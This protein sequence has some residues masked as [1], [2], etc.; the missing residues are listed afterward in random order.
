M[1][2]S[3]E[4]EKKVETVPAGEEVSLKIEET[5]PETSKEE[6]VNPDDIPF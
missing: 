4:A 2:E 5:K 3:I 1:T 6:L